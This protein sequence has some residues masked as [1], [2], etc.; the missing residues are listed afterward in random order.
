MEQCG[1]PK[2]KDDNHQQ[3]FSKMTDSQIVELRC[4]KELE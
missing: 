3:Y 4:V 1:A 2:R